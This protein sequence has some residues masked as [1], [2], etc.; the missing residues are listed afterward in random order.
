MVIYPF[1]GFMTEPVFP[2]YCWIEQRVAIS[3]YLSVFNYKN[4]G[5]ILDTGNF[6]Q[7]TSYKKTRN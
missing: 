6:I 3:V 7:R 5:T 4:R 1:I 2:K